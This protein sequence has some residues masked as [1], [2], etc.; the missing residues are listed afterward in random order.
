MNS[1]HFAYQELTDLQGRL[2]ETVNRLWSIH[3][4]LTAAYEE[5]QKEIDFLPRR[6]Y[7]RKKEVEL[8]L[9]KLLRQVNKVVSFHLNRSLLLINSEE[10]MNALMGIRTT[11]RYI[12]NAY[13]SELS[14]IHSLASFN[15]LLTT[16]PS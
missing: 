12:Q 9:E 14:L 6:L 3:G 7:Q 13:A 8:N 11:I 10:D 1:L 2:K 16:Y 15:R 4:I 5:G